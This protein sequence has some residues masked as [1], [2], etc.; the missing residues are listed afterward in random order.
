MGFFQLQK[1]TQAV[2]FP[3]DGGGIPG[4]VPNFRQFRF[5]GF[6]FRCQRFIA[7]HIAVKL[8]RLIRQ[9][10]DTGTQRGQNTFDKQI[11]HGSAGEGSDHR[12]RRGKQHRADQRDAYL[13]SKKVFHD[14]PSKIC[15]AI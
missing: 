12:Q 4:I 15:G 1:G 14:M 2:V 3:L 6:I 7:E 13:S 11:A 10:A 8:L 5:Q 9:R